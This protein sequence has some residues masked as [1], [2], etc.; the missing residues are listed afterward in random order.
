ML[1]SFGIELRRRDAAAADRGGASVGVR[2]GRRLA[3]CEIDVPGDFSAAAFWMIA[4]TIVP[5]S[6]LTLRNV[7]LNPGRTGLVRV[8]RRMG[9]AIDVE[10]GGLSTGEP[11]GHVRV[12]ASDLEAAEIGPE[13]VPALIDEIPAWAVAA[14]CARGVSRLRGAGELR[15][16]E[17]DRLSG[18]ARGL[19]ALGVGVEEYPD[20]LEIEGRGGG[21]SPPLA[22]GRLR[23]AG[24][25]RLAMAFAIAGLAS[26]QPVEVTG[27]A[28]VDTSYPGFYSTFVTLLSCR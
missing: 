25:H 17:S 4:A 13:E 10:D 16:K 2:G 20:G 7:G 21:G 3:P 8:L 28:M 9:A 1:P 26:K 24:D 15:V 5:G 11:F 6:D 27:A 12:R 22:G 23:A 19:R 14:A 18:I